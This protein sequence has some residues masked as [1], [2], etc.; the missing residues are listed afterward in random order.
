MTWVFSLLR[1]LYKEPKLITAALAYLELTPHPQSWR[2]PT[3][4]KRPFVEPLTWHN[5]LAV[6]ERIAPVAKKL[7]RAS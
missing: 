1:L 5:T 7:V 6:I 4:L 3:Q 2:S